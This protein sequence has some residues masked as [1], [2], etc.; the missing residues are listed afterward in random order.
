MRRLLVL[1]FL[2]LLCA[3][4]A[5]PPPATFYDGYSGQF[6]A[7]PFTTYATTG[8]IYGLDEQFLYVTFSNGAI[9]GFFPVP[10]NTAMA[11][12]YTNNP[13]TFYSTEILNL[14]PKVYSCGTP[15]LG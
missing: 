7:T 4:A 15:P 8:F 10:Q 14:Y 13:D 2:P 12:N 6:F 3:A 1:L 9:T 5:C 11:F